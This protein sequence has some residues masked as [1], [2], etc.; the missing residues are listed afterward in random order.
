MSLNEIFE[1]PREV[2]NELKFYV[3]RLID[4]R[5]GE[6]FYVGKG[7]GNRVFHHVKCATSN[8]EFDEVNDKLQKIREISAAGLEIIHVIHRHG[9]TNEIAFEVEAALLDAYPGTTNIMGGY[10]SNDYGPMNAKEIVEKYSAET[11]V[12]EHKILMIIINNSILERSIYDAT[13][14][15]WKIS[16]KN[17]NKAEYVLAVSQGIIKDVFVVDEKGWR[18]ATIENFP[19]LLSSRVG[20]Y[21]FSGSRAPEEVCKLYCGKK[22]PDVYRKKGASNPIKYTFK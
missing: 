22:I 18:E 5:N 1:F 7:Q 4:P 17:A 6:T 14:I 2:F 11:A 10:G 8:N 12:F 13:R 20:R 15:A 9:L 16:K 21:A 3:Y 19:E